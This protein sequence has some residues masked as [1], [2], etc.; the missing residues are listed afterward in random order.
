MNNSAMTETNQK[1]EKIKNEVDAFSFIVNNNQGF[2]RTYRD[3][4]NSK[5]ISWI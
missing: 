4:F 1:L 3:N 5:R 2:T